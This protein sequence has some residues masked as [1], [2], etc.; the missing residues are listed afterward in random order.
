[1]GAGVQRHLGPWP[2]AIPALAAGHNA[3]P[4]LIPGKRLV[5]HF[6]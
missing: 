2:S 1:M 3:I 6:S 5:Y 4:E